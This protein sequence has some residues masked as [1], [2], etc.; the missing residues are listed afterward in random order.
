MTISTSQNISVALGNGATNV[1]DFNFVGDAAPF[2]VVIYNDANGG[3][4]TLN[5]TQY[6][7]MLN[8]PLAGQLWGIGGTV[9]YPLSGLPIVNGTSITIQ[10]VLSLQQLSNLTD[11]GN[12]YPEAVE[13]ALDILE[14]QIQQVSGRTGQYRYTWISGAVYNYADIVQDGINGGNSGSYYFCALANT[15]S[16]WSTDL[17]NGDWVL[18]IPSVIPVAPLPLSIANGGTG[19][20]TSS[21]ALNALGGISLSGNNAFTGSNTFSTG[22]NT[23]SSSVV[24]TGSATLT[25]SATAITQA[26]G[27]STNS[28][29]TD[30]FVQQNIL[31][32]APAVLT[33]GSG[34]YTVPAMC[35]KLRIRGLGGGGSGAAAGVSNGNTGGTTSFGSSGAQGIANGG[36]GGVSGNASNAGGAGGTASNGN[37]NM[38]GNPGGASFATGSQII[39]GGGNGAPGIFGGGGSSGNASSNPGGNAVANSG[40]GGGGSYG[41]SNNASG[42]GAGGYFETWII[43]PAATYAYAVGAGGTAPTGAT[44]GGA[45]GSGILIIEPF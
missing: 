41:S 1:F 42:G 6:S 21:S 37:F 25:G 10:R 22:T 45:G 7:L 39:L 13:A 20:T 12:F 29:A 33:S 18:I 19:A 32:F 9:V 8:Q 26:V 4:T 17:S 2:I 16:V 30:A 36:G 15:S 44:V 23:F 40:A 38:Q 14:M 24:I 5:P 3:H 27:D 34:T 35:K 43:S 28:I 31:V 11:Q